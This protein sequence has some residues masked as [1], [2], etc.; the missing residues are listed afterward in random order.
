VD[1]RLIKDASGR[2]VRLCGVNVCSFE[3]DP[4]GR[5]WELEPQ[6]SALI[7]RLA[8]PSRWG[9]NVVRIPLNQQ[10]FLEDDGY[11][12]RVEL[13]L[14]SAAVHGLYAIIEPHWE[15]GRA[16]EPYH[17]NILKVPTFGSGNTTEAFWRKAIALW[18]HRPEVLYD[19]INEP[20]GGS[21]KETLQALQ[22]MCEVIVALQPDAVVIA[23]GPDWAHSVDVYRQRPL[24]GA[25]I[26]YS[27]HQYLPHDPPRTFE[28]NFGRL[29]Q[30][31]PVILGE[32]PADD[33]VYSLQVMEAAE[34]FD[35]SG[36]LLW[37]VGCGFSAEDPLTTEPLQSLTRAMRYF[38]QR[39]IP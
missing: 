19:L 1:G 32:F 3:F 35:L 29:S 37:A 18:G 15:V 2:R 31:A 30:T 39:S 13:V 12:Q 36:W 26:V 20:H 9:V 16:L 17:D 5:N 21:A 24:N 4:L 11:V 7:P 27:A 28:K 14:D 25:N 8:D 22:A 38:I 34:R 6:G 10:W 23:G 33:P